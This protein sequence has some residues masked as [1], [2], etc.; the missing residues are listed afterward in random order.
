MISWLHRSGIAGWRNDLG[1]SPPLLVVLLLPSESS[2]L[3]D[4]PRL[5]AT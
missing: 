3:H 2:P 1:T 4:V 5:G